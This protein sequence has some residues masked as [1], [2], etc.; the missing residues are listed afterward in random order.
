VPASLT[1]ADYPKLV[2]GEPVETVAVGTILGVYNSP[3]GSPRYEKLVRFVD[4]FFGQFDKFLAPQRHPKWREVNLAASVSGWTRF[5]PAQDWLDR[6]REPDGTAHP[7]LD[8]FLRS[9]PDRP[10][11]KEEVYQAYLKW[12]QSR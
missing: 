2:R 12:R 5:Q 9:R 7:E 3:K 4:A 8:R 1:R 11:G 6:H 10:A